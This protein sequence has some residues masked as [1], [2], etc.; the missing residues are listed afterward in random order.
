MNDAGETPALPNDKTMRV[1]LLNPPGDKPY[2][3]DYYCSH[4][5]KAKYYWHPYDLVVQSGILSQKHE[6]GFID[7]NLFGLTFEQAARHVSDFNPHAIVF[8][9]GGVCWKQDFA[10]LESLRIPPST[11]VI[12]TGDVLVSKGRQIMG[13][14]PWLSAILLDFTSHSIVDFLD[15]WHPREG[16]KGTNAPLAN[17]LYRVGDQFV[18]GVDPGNRYY[19]FPIPRYDLLPLR[20]YRLPHAKHRV[21]ASFLTDFG[22]PYAC[23]FCFNGKWPH[24]LRDLDNAMQELHHVKRLGIREL[25]IKDLTFGVNRSHS[26]EF[27]HRLINE[28]L[29]LDWITLSRVDVMDEEML[30]LMSQAG[31]HTIQFGVESADQGI[32]NSIEKQIEPQ[33]V[34]DTFALCRK[35]NIRT[36]AHFIIGLPGETEETA[37]ATIE[38]AKEIEP[39]YASFNVAA[40]RMG[41]DLR[42]KA[43]REGWTSKDADAIDNSIAFPQMEIGTLSGERIRELRNQAIREFHLRPSYLWRKATGWRSVYELGR[44]ARNGLALLRSTLYKHVP[45]D[46]TDGDI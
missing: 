41:T 25:W 34:R 30:T 17:L 7:A 29:Q 20:K 35:L 1:L 27:L 38:F 37:R 2:L 23:H 18:K 32:L 19:S 4:S 3:R 6:V 16:Y 9:T 31:C 46:D 10:F 14:Y 11:P 39:D 15:G 28:N 26:T 33:R 44:D 45:A 22:C 43:I 40:P 5:A 12:G 21:F 24:K 13:L 8:L 36:L 42:E